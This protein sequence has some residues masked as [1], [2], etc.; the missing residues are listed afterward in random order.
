MYLSQVRAVL[1][2]TIASLQHEHEAATA[3]L[4]SENRRLQQALAQVK[5]REGELEAK[6]LG[7]SKQMSGLAEWTTKRADH[8]RS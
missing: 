7:I 4:K 2:E 8:R 5:A 1:S 6:L 3:Q